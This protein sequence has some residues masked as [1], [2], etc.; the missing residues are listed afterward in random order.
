MTTTLDAQQIVG[1]SAAWAA[2]RLLEEGYNELPSSR[3]RTILA[4]GLEVIREPMFLLLVACGL[5]YMFTGELTDALMLLSF[6]LVVVGSRNHVDHRAQR[7]LRSRVVP[8]QPLARGG[9]RTLRGRRCRQ[10]PVVGG[11]QGIGFAIP[12]SF[13][14]P[15][16]AKIGDAPAQTSIA[17]ESGAP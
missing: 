4:I 15:L 12:I 16:L 3:Q 11:A 9:H 10:H 7:A 8:F 2:Q 5:L 6:V 13:V 17:G 14:K 1:L